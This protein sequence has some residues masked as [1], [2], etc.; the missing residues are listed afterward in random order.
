MIFVAN[1]VFIFISYLLVVFLYTM[2]I[3]WILL[4]LCVF[5]TLVIMLIISIS[6]HSVYKIQRKTNERGFTAMYPTILKGKENLIGIII[7]I[8]IMTMCILFLIIG[9]AID[10]EQGV[11]PLFVFKLFLS[12]VL[13]LIHELF[14]IFAVRGDGLGALVFSGGTSNPGTYEDYCQMCKERDIEP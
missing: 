3:P 7:G 4:A 1:T 12:F 9:I 13:F 11:V 2:I 10:F 8:T 5:T 6:L 14:Y